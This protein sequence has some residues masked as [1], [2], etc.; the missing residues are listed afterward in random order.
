MLIYPINILFGFRLSISYVFTY[1]GVSIPIILG[2]LIVS[3]F[4]TLF[5]AKKVDVSKRFALL[6]AYSIAVY[7]ITAIMLLY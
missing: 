7:G 3:S 5:V 4:I 2:C 1:G 6:T